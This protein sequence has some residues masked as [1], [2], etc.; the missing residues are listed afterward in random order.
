MTTPPSRKVLSNRRGVTLI[1]LLWVVIYLAAALWVLSRPS[2]RAVEIAR[3]V[4]GDM[5]CDTSAAVA[6]FLLTLFSWLCVSVG[7]YRLCMRYGG[8]LYFPLM[9]GLP[10]GFAAV[11]F[12]PFSWPI[13]TLLLSASLIAVPLLLFFIQSVMMLL[14]R[15]TSK[16]KR[17][18]IPDGLP[19]F[20]P[21]YVRHR[22]EPV[23]IKEGIPHPNRNLAWEKYYN[24]IGIHQGFALDAYFLDADVK[25]FR[26]Q[27]SI[28]CRKLLAHYK[29]PS[30][31]VRFWNQ[32]WYSE[33]I[34]I[35]LVALDLDSAR[36]WAE[37]VRNTLP[38][39]AH[40]L[41]RRDERIISAICATIVNDEET[42]LLSHQ[43]LKQ[44]V[45]WLDGMATREPDYLVILI[46]GIAEQNNEL[47]QEAIRIQAEEWYAPAL[48]DYYRLNVNGVAMT[49]L[50]RWRG[51]PIPPLE[52]VIP[53][54]LLLKNHTMNINVQS[55]C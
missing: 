4:T 41:S 24:A 11:P 44:P 6:A 9:V 34:V 50:C 12:H 10:L 31:Y 49:N 38:A 23:N 3:T 40:L 32:T 18:P 28:Y 27:Y 43:K 47:C 17:R 36:D 7:I 33:E 42:L 15:K 14:Y 20:S 30:G 21:G 51:I 39:N 19:P 8:F 46:A 53:E 35:P 13:Y 45:G 26:N 25:E 5:R 2:Y 16:R 54:I 52:P 22:T 37:Y 48:S 55:R 29:Q 1:E